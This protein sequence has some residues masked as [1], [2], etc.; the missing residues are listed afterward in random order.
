M[1]AGFPPDPP[2]P[3]SGVTDEERFA[4]MIAY[5]SGLVGYVV[6]IPL[7]SL[8]GPCAMYFIYREQSKFIAFHA[9]QAIYLQLASLCI[10]MG[11]AIGTILTCGIG[12][13]IAKPILGL[14]WFVMVVTTLFMA[15]K[16]NRGEIY[17]LWSIGPRARRRVGV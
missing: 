12:F 3:A 11:M 5:L 16:A 2:H 9:L 8:I 7:V 1:S 4:S 14:L 17:E 10:I 6:V 13:I 15:V